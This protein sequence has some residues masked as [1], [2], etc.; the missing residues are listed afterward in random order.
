MANQIK[1]SGS[2]VAL[3][4]SDKI[5]KADSTY[6]DLS[7]TGQSKFKLEK[8]YCQRY[9]SVKRPVKKELFYYHGYYQNGTKMNVV[10]T[11]EGAYEDP[12]PV[13]FAKAR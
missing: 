9:S 5:E 2:A 7:V 12:K 4:L 13:Y 1:N 3:L 10:K 8:R 11:R 6:G